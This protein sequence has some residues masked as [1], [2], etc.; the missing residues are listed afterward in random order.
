MCEKG[1]SL[2]AVVTKTLFL[3]FRTS[4]YFVQRIVLGSV[5]RAG[6]RGS[7]RVG[8]D[9]LVR[10]LF[11]TEDSRASE[12]LEVTLAA[13]EGTVAEK[14]GGRGNKGRSHGLN[15]VLGREAEQWGTVSRGR[16]WA[17]T[18]LPGAFP[19][20][21]HWVVT[22]GHLLPKQWP[23]P[24][25]AP[26]TVSLSTCQPVAS[27]SPMVQSCA[28]RAGELTGQCISRCVPTQR[29]LVTAGA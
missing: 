27:R 23:V 6:G 24:P 18:L 28:G 29:C 5:G 20:W 14:G 11:S 19:V 15:R 1:P 7:W 26:G 8:L 4:Q 3:S 13:W 16:T 9:A 17:L 12:R 10:A 2:E 22:Q 25:L 21:L